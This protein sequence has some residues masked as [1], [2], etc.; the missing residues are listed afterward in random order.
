[1]NRCFFWLSSASAAAAEVPAF[2]W[3]GNAALWNVCLSHLSGVHVFTVDIF[4]AQTVL[5]E[6]TPL[7][8]R[9]FPHF[10]PRCYVNRAECKSQSAGARAS[11]C[12]AP[13][14]NASQFFRKW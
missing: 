11:L 7:N 4:N 9:S 2:Y 5:T 13:P 3:Q 12:F 1:M 10:R 14:G 6:E 8:S